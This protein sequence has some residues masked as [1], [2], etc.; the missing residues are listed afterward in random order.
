MVEPG[1]DL[2][3]PT[4][5]YESI[6]LSTGALSVFLGGAGAFCIGGN[7]FSKPGTENCLEFLLEML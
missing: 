3:S 5:S 6:V 7:P 4:P 1:L 2:G